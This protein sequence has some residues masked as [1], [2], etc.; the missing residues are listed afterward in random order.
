MAN[1]LVLSRC[2][3]LCT[4]SQGGRPRPPYTLGGKL[5]TEL[6]NGFSYFFYFFFVA[7]KQQWHNYAYSTRL[8]KLRLVTDERKTEIA[9]WIASTH[10]FKAIAL[11][12]K[13][14]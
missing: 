5:M 1:C 8:M 3:A 10:I 9:F 12:E 7:L 14:T 13:A 4:V 11:R 6:P 2:R